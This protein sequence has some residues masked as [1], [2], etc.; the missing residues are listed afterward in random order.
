MLW[1]GSRNLAPGS[2]TTLSG[3]PINI[4][5]IPLPSDTPLFLTFIALHIAAGLVCVIAGAVAMLSRKEWGRHPR[6]GVIYYRALTIVF[7]TMAVIGFFRWSEDYHL[8]IL[9]TLSFLAATIGR[10]ARRRLRPGWARVH[11][12]GMG[13]SYILL[14]TAF[15]VDN[16]PNLPLWRLLPQITFWF[17]P[18]TIGTP[19]L[20][21]ALVWHPLVRRN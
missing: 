9:G 21:Y 2:A 4:G 16:G 19:I 11:M 3:N 15:Y 13:A 18:A 17:L 1:R 5:G 7:V 6:A 20:V 14:L 10:R 12:T 8:V